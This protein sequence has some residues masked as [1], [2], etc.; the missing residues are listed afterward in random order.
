ML[1]WCSQGELVITWI[2]G[3]DR[4]EERPDMEVAESSC[5]FPHV[6]KNF[7]G[8][9]DMLQC[10]PKPGRA[11]YEVYLAQ[12]IAPRENRTPT[13]EWSGMELCRVAEVAREHGCHPPKSL[14][15][16]K[17]FKPKHALFCRELRIVAIYPLFGDLW[18]KKVSLWYILHIS[19][20]SF[21]KFAQKRCI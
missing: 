15:L 7:L 10:T 1:T 11:K 17:N 21:C 2:A 14:D 16:D 19:L 5:P 20:S 18:A 4:E 8:R 9:R 6:V 12:R 3:L 13:Q